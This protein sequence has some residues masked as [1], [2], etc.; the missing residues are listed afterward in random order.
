MK[1][2]FSKRGEQSSFDPQQVAYLIGEV[3]YSYLHLITGEVVLTCRTLKWFAQRWPA[4]LRLHK[5]ALVNAHY[6]VHYQL[7][8]PSQTSYVVMR[9][10]T[11]LPVARR[12]V[13]Q[14][15]QVL[16]Q[17]LRASLAE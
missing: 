1:R 2:I 5:K 13:E 9:D 3:N 16:N 12:R 10:Q 14:V 15:G 17:L 7:G 4:F 8:N 11:Q 6:I